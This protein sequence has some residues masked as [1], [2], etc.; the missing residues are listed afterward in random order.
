MKEQRTAAILSRHPLADDQRADLEA[1]GFTRFVQVHPPQRFSS[2]AHAW[3]E[4]TMACG[5]KPDLAVV[6][7][8]RSFFAPFVERAAR[9]KLP[10]V[11]S[12]FYRDAGWCGQWIEA[13][14]APNGEIW[15]R[16]W[17]EPR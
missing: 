16:L 2:A 14:L 8:P 6:V 15:H 3:S 17:G 7:L 4:M 9:H 11:R 10:V 1:R 13:Y 5:G 12:L